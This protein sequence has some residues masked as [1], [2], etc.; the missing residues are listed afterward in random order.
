MVSDCGSTGKS[1]GRFWIVS[2]LYGPYH[3]MFPTLTGCIRSQS[4]SY[5]GV[6]G[7]RSCT[8]V[9]RGG[10]RLVVVYRGKRPSSG[11]HRDLILLGRLD[12][13]AKEVYDKC[14]NTTN[15]HM[16]VVRIHRK[17]G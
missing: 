12:T 9:S 17:G 6:D 15:T 13:R 4:V 3:T 14:T 10:P 2:R 7:D 5:P 8:E 1:L 11:A 16:T